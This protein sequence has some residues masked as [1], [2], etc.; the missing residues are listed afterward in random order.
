VDGGHNGLGGH[1]SLA[2]ADEGHGQ[3]HAVVVLCGE[4][5]DQEG[6]V[7]VVAVQWSGI[8]K[9]TKNT[10]LIGRYKPGCS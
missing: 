6:V 8:R 9:E 1:P 2:H 5:S 3:L 4:Q 7:V 10:K